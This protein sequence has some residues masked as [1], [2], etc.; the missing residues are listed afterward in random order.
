MVRRM[1]QWFVQ[2]FIATGLKPWFPVIEGALS[3]MGFLAGLISLSGLF[4]YLKEQP[5]LLSCR[6]WKI[7]PFLG[8]NHSA[9]VNLMLFA[10]PP[11]S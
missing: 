4:P 10:I 8:H 5:T 1:T 9:Y 2:R 3:H 11:S 7:R 6:W